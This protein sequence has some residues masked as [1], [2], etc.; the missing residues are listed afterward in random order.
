MIRIARL[1]Q[2][3]ILQ[4]SATEWSRELCQARQEYYRDL[5]QYEQGQRLEKPKY[6]D[7]RKSR[8]AHLQVQ[9]RLTE[10]FGSKCAY[11]ESRIRA[12]TH[13]HVEHF[14]HARSAGSTAPISRMIA[15]FG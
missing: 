1:A 6:P 4:K 5:A 11:C 10:M 3:D 9:K 2:P 13:S 12:V 8:Y 14:R 15:S 7:A